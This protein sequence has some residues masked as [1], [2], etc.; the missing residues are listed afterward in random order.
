M[1]QSIKL[2]IKFLL[3]CWFAFWV[4]ISFLLVYPLLAVAL[5]KTNWY[6]YAVAIRRKWVVFLLF[7]GAIRVKTIYEK[8]LTDTTYVI[9]PNHTSK[10]DMIVLQAKLKESYNFAA[11]KAFG[12][13]PL[14]GTFFRTVDIPVNLNSKLGA[15]LAYRR[16]V[17]Q[18]R[19][20]LSL[21]I[22]PEGT[23]S[24]KTPKLSPFKEGA[25]KMAIAAGCPVLPVTFI[26]SW[27]LL[28]YAGPLQYKPGE[29]VMY[30]HAPIPT[31]DMQLSQATELRDRVFELMANKLKGYGYQPY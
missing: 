10:L 8:P 7:I 31:K 30:V 9:T 6:R 24:R 12:E 29:V 14:F 13:I 2:G 1:I 16:G 15:A 23:I 3:F 4:G 18:L 28:P 27:N 21:C 19:T 25:F 5:L 11:N 20:G 22:F 26:H 17:E